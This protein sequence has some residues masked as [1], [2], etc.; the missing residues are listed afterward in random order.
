MI[1]Q[2]TASELTASGNNAVA[3][4]ATA[5]IN[6]DPKAAMAACRALIAQEVVAT[7]YSRHGG[8]AGGLVARLAADAARVEFERIVRKE[9]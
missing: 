7:V 3:L 8:E 9:E 6:G 1:N 2:L 4:A 5:I